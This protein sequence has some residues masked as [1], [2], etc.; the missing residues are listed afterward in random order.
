MRS[1]PNV[2][3]LIPTPE[4]FRHQIFKIHGD[5]ISPMLAKI[6]SVKSLSMVHKQLFLLFMLGILDGYRARLTS[7]GGIWCASEE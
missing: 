2:R 7:H 4:L 1:R 3:A 5:L 6:T